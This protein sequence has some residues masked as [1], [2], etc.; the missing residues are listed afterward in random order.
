[1]VKYLSP[2]DLHVHLR[3]TEYDTNYAKLA[4]EDARSVGLKA[5]AEMPNPV[6]QLVDIS[7]INNR[8]HDMSQYACGTYDHVRHI[9]NIGLT[10]DLCQVRDALRLIMNNIVGIKADKVFYTHSTGNMGILDEDYQRE[11]WKL[12]RDLGYTGV[13]MAH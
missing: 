13:S 3:G 11:I 7:T 1:M 4:F 10:N 6:P 12:K 8:F 5:M 2:I 9:I